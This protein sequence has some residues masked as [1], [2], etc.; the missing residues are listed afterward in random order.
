VDGEG[1]PDE[2]IPQKV[3]GWQET[4]YLLNFLA[5]KDDKSQRYS[6]S[7]GADTEVFDAAFRERIRG[8]VNRIIHAIGCDATAVIAKTMLLGDEERHRQ[9]IEWNATTRAYPDE[10]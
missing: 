4:N 2:W 6:L 9:L 7:I 5:E 1:T 8:Y 3:G 10:R